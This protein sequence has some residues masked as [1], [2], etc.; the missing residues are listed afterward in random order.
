MKTNLDGFAACAILALGC[1]GL[2]VALD[3]PANQGK[4][5]PTLEC[6]VDD[7]LTFVAFN[8]VRWDMEGSTVYAVTEGEDG[9][10]Y[11]LE[12]A[13]L[14]GETCAERAP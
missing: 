10:R 14:A 7:T 13:V 1:C 5:A 9:K 8:V 12:R 11:T 4:P 6:S 3:N 2:I